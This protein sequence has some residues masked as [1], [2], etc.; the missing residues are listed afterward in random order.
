MRQYAMVGAYKIS[1]WLRNKLN[2]DA[3][4]RYAR[5]LKANVTKESL[6]VKCRYEF[7]YSRYKS[8]LIKER[9][10]K[11]FEQCRKSEIATT[12]IEL[13]FLEYIDNAANE[14]FGL[15]T[16]NVDRGVSLDLAAKIAMPEEVQINL[17][18]E[19][20]EARKIVERVL[21]LEHI[22]SDSIKDTFRVDLTLLNYLNGVD[23]S[24]I[25]R[26]MDISGS[27]SINQNPNKNF[28]KSV[29][30]YSFQKDMESSV[31]FREEIDQI[32]NQ[33]L[34]IT[35]A[36]ELCPVIHI[37]GERQ[38][39]KKFM[40]RH[41]SKR[42]RH[43]L[44]IYDYVETE[45]GEELARIIQKL[46]RTV[47]IA[48]SALCIFLSAQEKN[49]RSKDVIGKIVKIIAGLENDREKREI[50]IASDS[51][52]KI[53]P[54][55]D[56]VV[57]QMEIKKPNEIQSFMLW[58]EFLVQYLGEEQAKKLDIRELAVK[59]KVAA[60]FV[61]KIAH[62]F[63]FAGSDKISNAE[64]VSK[65]CYMIL[66]DGKY[67]DIR[68]IES[69]YSWD[70]L[71]LEAAQKNIL[72]DIYSHVK[73]RLKVYEDYGLRQKFQYGRCI[74]ALF[75]GPSGTGKT[76]AVYVL[77]N[78]LHL[79]LYKVD[80]SKVVDKY[81]G[82][83]EKRLEEVFKKA[84]NSNMILFFDEADALFGKRSEIKDARDKYAN[85]EVAYILQKIEEFDGI[86]ILSTN[87][88]EN[89]DVA[90]M[91]RMKYEVRFSMP[92]KE[93]REEI[94]R[95]VLGGKVITDVIDYEY[96]AD[97]FEFSGA[98]IKNVALNAI[99][100]AVSQDMA[101][102]MEHI[103]WAVRMEYEKT[104]KMVFR[105]EFGKYGYLIE[106]SIPAEKK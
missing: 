53:I 28:G 93:M 102:S 51:R 9:Y 5:I 75:S 34:K 27:S 59:M 48:E 98:S 24:D 71:K 35:E 49:D 70:D 13:A 82:E 101:V 83:T 30:L 11:V 74:S 40:I 68:H 52:F 80:L 15:I 31:L 1:Y 47:F 72:K 90:F 91:R 12:C 2:P 67:D 57:C 20:Y 17:S 23:I 92:P 95:N 26:E 78:M 8:K 29:R 99:F 104:G 64:F 79:E 10:K 65:I 63:K 96:L 106:K 33:V 42:L 77:A 6:D 39:G 45:N 97:N 86:V 100:K 105:E 44:L 73:Y 103:V 61:K 38:S 4:Q 66:N 19:I 18:K 87:Y 88:R 89:V 85:T 56:N 16:G 32:S 43:N 25:C 36:D 14:V 3:F 76:M 55:I 58:K 94:W 37:I 41:I 22:Y 81:I 50:Y 7:D 21:V 62:Y 46:K 84:E 54:Y 60:G 69:V